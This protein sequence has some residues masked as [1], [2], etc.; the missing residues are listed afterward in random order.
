MKWYIV[1]DSSIPQWQGQFAESIGYW[2][3]VSETNKEGKIGFDSQFQRCQYITAG[4]VW[5]GRTAD[6]REGQKTKKK[7][8]WHR[9]DFITFS[10]FIPNGQLAMFR[11]SL[12][13]R[14]FFFF[15]LE[16]FSFSGTQRC[17]SSTSWVIWD[18]AKLITKADQLDTEVHQFVRWR[19]NSG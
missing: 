7:Q 18:L 14:P 12:F 15:F 6:F 19:S 5:W 9:P 13:H 11:V 17:A 16:I 1:V 10:L 8:C 3:G 2:D 4:R